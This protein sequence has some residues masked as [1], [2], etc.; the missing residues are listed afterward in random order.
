MSSTLTHSK[1]AAVHLDRLSKLLK[2]MS[3]LGASTS[4]VSTSIASI[5]LML[6][7]A[8]VHGNAAVIYAASVDGRTDVVTDDR[9]DPSVALRAA[10]KT[11][12][13]RTIKRIPFR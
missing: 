3:D 10:S 9:V 7:Q 8:S 2:S 6:Q 12:M 11:V 13:Q 4:N 5:A 1:G